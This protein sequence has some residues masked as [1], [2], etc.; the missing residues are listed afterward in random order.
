MSVD[1]SS[2]SDTDL[3]AEANRRGLQL[4]SMA[5]SVAAQDVLRRADKMIH[6]LKALQEYV[7]ALPA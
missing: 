7:K 5:F 4:H 2:V 3:R 1:L 6:E